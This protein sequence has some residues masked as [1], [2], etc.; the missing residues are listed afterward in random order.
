MSE[1]SASGLV[2]S[3]GLYRPQR[4]VTFT[5]PKPFIGPKV[6]LDSHNHRKP[7]HIGRSL[8][9]GDGKIRSIRKRERDTCESDE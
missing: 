6:N 9:E 3:T 2:E 5:K 1:N 4:K 8:M 7:L